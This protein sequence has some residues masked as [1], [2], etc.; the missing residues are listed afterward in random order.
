MDTNTHAGARPEGVSASFSIKYMKTHELR[1]KTNQ[2]L[3][4]RDF[5]HFCF[6]YILYWCTFDSIEQYRLPKGMA[7]SGPRSWP[8]APRRRLWPTAV[9]PHPPGPTGRTG[10]TATAVP[11]VP[12][13][14]LQAIRKSIISPPPT[15]HYLPAVCLHPIL[16]QIIIILVRY[17]QQFCL[18]RN[19]SF[20]TLCFA[21]F[22]KKR[23]YQNMCIDPE[24]R[25]AVFR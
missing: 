11:I 1:I 22:L 17:F 5:F 2:T 15:P 24:I 16:Y 3:V 18:S 7:F 20:Q 6:L 8:W 13:W 23:V 4:V 21:L 12:L 25:L 10:P 14:P 19:V 9:S